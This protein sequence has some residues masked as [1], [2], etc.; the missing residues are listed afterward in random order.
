MSK[1]RITRKADDSS[2]ST[3][4]EESLEFWAKDLLKRGINDIHGRGKDLRT[5]DIQY[6]DILAKLNKKAPNLR[7]KQYEEP[8]PI[9]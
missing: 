5:S 6:N 1:Y 9:S 3:E 4:T 8:E 2:E 7:L